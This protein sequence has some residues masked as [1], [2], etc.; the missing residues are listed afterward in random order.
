[1]NAHFNPQDMLGEKAKALL[2][3]PQQLLIGGKLLDA[4][5]GGT[6]ETFDPATGKAIARAAHATAADVDRAVK[7]ASDALVGP[8]GRMSPADRAAR[9]MRLAELIESRAQE[10]AEIESLDSGKPVEHIKFVDIG[11]SVDALRYNAGW[12]TKIGGET[13][14][15]NAPDMHVYTRREP[16]GV[17]A[18]IVPWNFPLCQACFKI[19]PAL[20]AGCTIVLKPAEQTP[21]SALILGKLALEAGIPEGVLNVLQGEGE[22]TGEALISHP[23]IAKIAFTGSETV[24]K[25]IAR[26]A[27][28]TLKHVSLELGGKNPNIVFA[29]ADIEAALQTAAIAAFFYTGQ[30]CSAGSRIMVEKKVFDRAAETL[31][32]EASKQKVGYGL[33]TDTTMGPL[34]STEQRDRVASYVEQSRQTGIR[35]AAGGDIPSDLPPAGSF[36]KPTILLD[37][38]DNA[39][40]AREE[41][42]GPVVIVQPFEDLDEIARRANDTT[43]G[44]AAGVWTRDIGR[45]HKLASMLQTGTVW[46][47]T[48]N[49]F[50][51]SAPWG[52]YKQSGFGRDNGKEGI[53]KFLQTKTVWVNCA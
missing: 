42:F 7:A 11:L 35:V 44:L 48:Y 4:S 19:A 49:Q 9:L 52:G 34:I 53:E 47:N 17:V 40:V 29:D 31:I 14:P 37:V 30:V 2:G 45:A 3:A 38:D 51:A 12:A 23:S 24:G 1:M 50:D 27:A 18:A 36:Y 46:I 28:S 6:I 33:A 5:D 16:I 21:L 25:H 15:V 20:A 13:L 22:T 39:R 32:A 10:I 26:S 8:W 41:I 43:F